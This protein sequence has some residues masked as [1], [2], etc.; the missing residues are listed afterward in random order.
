MKR[1]TFQAQSDQLQER[2]MLAETATPPVAR[3]IPQIV[4]LLAVPL[5]LGVLG[6][7]LR[8]FAFLD[9]GWSPSFW[10]YPDGLCRWDCLW[11]VNLAQGG[12][13]TYPAAS[14]LDNGNWAFFP[15]FPMLVGG[16]YAATQVVAIHIASL[17]SML[18]SG[19]AVLTA[20]PLLGRDLKAYTLYAAFLLC[21]PF[22]IYF[23][24]FYT[25]VLFVL[26][27]NGVLL[28]LQRSNYF[29]AGALSALLSATRIVGVFIVFAIALNYLI[30]Y[31]AHGGTWRR[32]PQAIWRDPTIVLAVLLVPL[33]TFA[34]MAY[35]YGWM[36]DALAFSH[37]Q[38]AW[39]RVTGN[40]LIYLWDALTDFSGDAFFLSTPQWLGLSAVVGLGLTAVL[41]WRRRYPEA[42]FCLI[43]LVVPL[44]AGMA[45]MLRFVA[46]L[47]PIVL[48][49]MNLLASRKLLFVVVLAAFVVSDYFFTVG[50]LEEWLPLV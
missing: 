14:L 16:L 23:T 32:L 34:F 13:D 6:Y 31:R 44:S 27:T 4:I 2:V 45:S 9:A 48:L 5:G 24:T 40:P 7:V 26:L 50:W 46:A 1:G 19:L 36:G 38:R 8:L 39:G 15:L 33:G 22:S 20:W 17:L 21:G 43:C 49:A 41:A 3:R 11:Y 28:A 12:Y 35:L 18:F 42:L 10:N 25:E 30:D 29:A 37:V 47:S